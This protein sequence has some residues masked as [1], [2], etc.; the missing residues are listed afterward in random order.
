MAKAGKSG[1]AWELAF[2][3]YKIEQRVRDY[4]Y[5]DISAD[6]IRV[7]RE[8]RLMSKIDHSH[9][10]PGIFQQHKLNILT[11]STKVFR[12]GQF[13]IFETLPTWKQPG[14]DVEILEFPSGL[15]TLDHKNISGEPAVINAAFASGM[16]ENFTNQG[17]L[18]LTTNGRMRTPEFQYVV[19]THDGKSQNISVSSAQIEIDAGYEGS[20]A[21]F[22]FE[23]KNHI[24]KDFNMRQLYYP[25]RVWKPRIQKPVRSVFLMLS[26]D[27]F[28]FFEYEFEDPYNFSSGTIVK[29]KRYMLTHTKP[30]ESE[31]VNHAKRS[32]GKP[33]PETESFPQADLFER[34][35]D[36]TNYIL[37]EPR[38]IDDLDRDYDLD[39]RDRSYYY[40]AVRYLGLAKN[41]NIDGEKYLLATDLA[42]EIFNKSHK[43]KYEALA[44]LVLG[45]DTI[46]RIYLETLKQGTAPSRVWAT[47]VLA[48]SQDSKGAKPISGTTIERRAQTAL[49]WAA[50]VRSVSN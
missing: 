13:D 8:P 45:I 43:E 23:V 26:N 4:G 28:D 9:Q 15:E 48:D 32:V 20:K 49:A 46:A 21:F 24:A 35:I 31:L 30:K 34:V 44:K 18:L 7:F 5:A 17:D 6:E 40:K 22:I 41:S 37:Q 2:E 25:F 3:K 50:W 33:P 1:Q 29:Q 38:T 11:L 19:D 14:S 47:R 39:K 10:L 27:V 12:I 42:T 36:L 16:L